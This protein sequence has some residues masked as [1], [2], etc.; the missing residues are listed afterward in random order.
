MYSER[1]ASAGPDGLEIEEERDV[2]TLKLEFL[3][4]ID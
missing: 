2:E 1:T 3:T 4:L